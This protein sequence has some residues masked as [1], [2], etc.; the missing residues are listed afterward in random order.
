[1]MNNIKELSFKVRKI[2]SRGEKIIELIGV[3]LLQGASDGLSWGKHYEHTLF[4]SK[5]IIKIQKDYTVGQS[6]PIEPLAV[7]IFTKD[8]KEIYVIDKNKEEILVIKTNKKNIK[9]AREKNT[10]EDKLFKDIEAI[11]KNIL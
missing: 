9:L 5:D 2:S 10:L 1:M 6:I 7:E 4:I 8:I 3:V 11:I